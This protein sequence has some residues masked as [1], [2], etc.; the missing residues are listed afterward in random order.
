LTK[1]I[2]DMID[3]SKWVTTIPVATRLRTIHADKK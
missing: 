1:S 2:I 3:S